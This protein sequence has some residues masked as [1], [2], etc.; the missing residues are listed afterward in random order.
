MLIIINL[1]INDYKGVLKMKKLFLSF[2][3]FS[4]LVVIGCQE[5]TITDPLI[6]DSPGVKAVANETANKDIPRDFTD[7]PDIIKFQKKLESPFTPVTAFDKHT[8]VAGGTIKFEHNVDF[9]N[10]P[11]PLYRVI[12]NLSINAELKET[13][14]GGSACWTI[15]GE[16][17]DVIYLSGNHSVTRIKYFE[18]KG[19]SDG[20]ML[21]CRF[22]IDKDGIALINLW[23]DVAQ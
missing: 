22:G 16:T 20:M 7:H 9:L 23:L 21:A 8:F 13:W 14:L 5:N 15:T 19:R 10:P 4:V 2:V 6:T 3:V 12:V 1:F 11:G 17:K 18:I